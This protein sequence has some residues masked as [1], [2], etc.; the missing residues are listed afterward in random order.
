MRKFPFFIVSLLLLFTTAT[1][2][3]AGRVDPKLQ[4]SLESASPDQKVPV[5]VT[6]ATRVDLSSIQDRGKGVRRSKM[7]DALRRH[8]D[9]AQGPLLA[10]LQSRGATRIVQLWAINA[11]AATVP[12]QAID[13]LANQPGVDTVQLDETFNAPVP[14][15]GTTVVPEWNIDTIRAPELWELGYTGQG[16][17]VANM[18]TGVDVAHPDLNGRWR[19]GTNS[20]FDP[21]YEH[22]T[23]FDSNG[24]GTQT[25]GIIV[26]GDAGGTAIGVAP[27]ARWIAVKIFNDAGQASF[28]VVHQGFQWFLDPDGN[29][30]TDDAADV[31]NNS[32]QLLGAN[33]CN[34][35]FQ[36]DILMLKTAG[37]AVVFAAGNE[38]PAPSTS[39]SPAN[40]PGGFA[41]G[42]VDDSLTIAGDNSR[43][44]SACGGTIFPEVV[45]PGVNVK[46]A[47]LS[48]GGYAF[49]S[50]VSGTSVA[51]P[52]ISGAMALLI[53]AF[54]NVTVADLEG[55]LKESAQ[56]LGRVG[57]DNIYG[58]GLID[59]V[60]A[61]DLLRAGNQESQVNAGTDQTVYRQLRAKLDGTVTDDGL[62]PMTTT[63]TKQSGP[64]TV[65]FRNANAQD[66]TATFSA[67][68]TYVLRL[69]ANDGM[70][71]PV[72][73]DVQIIVNTNLHVGDLDGT[74]SNI[75]GKRWRAFVTVMVHNANIAIHGGVSGATVTGTWSAGNG[76]GRQ[77][78]CTTNGSGTCTVQSGRL[79]RATAASVRFTV[80]G[81]TKAGFIYQ[82]RANHDPDGDSTG[83]SITV[84]RP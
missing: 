73:D 47:D 10:F 56:D 42:S 55:A 78:S 18:D 26:G 27:G 24:H 22:D 61:R 28:S 65:T 50:T 77:L 59:V 68:G 39:V 14:T 9:R 60:L 83:T 4:E 11:I 41:V 84:N 23:P 36:P 70:N 79:S 48:F 38:G 45:A 54:A 66:T 8:A 7:V 72:S 3:Q 33:L 57:A 75:G 63:W 62:P 49:Y 76:N 52:H 37:I 67:A 20:W 53:S 25:M 29:A 34:R 46:T 80:T 16:V 71:A 74:S 40:N 2:V 19:G 64:G 44:P 58:Y 35:E 51:A 32:W 31:V 30:S 82:S 13:A 6:L 43:G 17:V 12:S 15:S 69:T 81:V 21:H 1:N 5:I